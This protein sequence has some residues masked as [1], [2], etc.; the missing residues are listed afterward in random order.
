M[1]RLGSTNEEALAHARRGDAG[2]L[3]ISAD[4]QTQG[5]GR[6]G[7]SWVSPVGNLY[8]SLMFRTGAAPSALPQLAH[9]AAV[10]LV[11]AIRATASPVSRLCIK[12]PNDVLVD[13]AK[14]AGILVEATMAPDRTQAC[15]IGWGVNCSYHPE[16][17]AYLTTDLSRV[18]GRAISA[19]DLLQHLRPAM[20][21]HLAL[22]DEGRGFGEI[23][24]LWL[25]DALPV[26]TPL[27]VRS[28]REQVEGR[29]QGID[30]Q[31]RLLLLGPHG[32]V[33]VEAGDVFLDERSAASVG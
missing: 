6:R 5:R 23:R 14:V 8:V 9:V 11:Q 32:P 28:D 2:P 18:S 21:E 22:W 26:D 19:A 31:G 12:W 13:K 3:W 1:A 29:F 15:V 27:T 20:A 33:T 30:G 24:A 16:G 7:R 4:Q 17:L 10:A 25:A